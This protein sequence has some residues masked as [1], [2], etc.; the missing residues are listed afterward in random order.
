MKRTMF[1]MAW[2]LS[3]FIYNQARAQVS[4]SVNIGVQPIW[5]P[6]GYDHVDFY[7]LP[8]IDCYYDVPG[9][10][11]VCFEKGNWVRMPNL[12]P[13]YAQF[14]LYHAYKVVLNEREPWLHHDAIRAKYAMYK[15]HHEQAVIRDSHEQK[16]WE[17]R[18]HPMHSQWHSD[19]R[20]DD[21]HDDHH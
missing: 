7:Y 1:I 18:D 8:D 6:V 3:G 9:H 5:G 12:P 16:Y 4:V 19:V 10:V 14:D 2:V 11:F 17:N 15:G 21:H 20:H 13:R